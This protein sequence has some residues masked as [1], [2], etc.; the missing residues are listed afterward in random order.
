M[1]IE[2]C[3]DINTNV[4]EIHIPPWDKLRG[5]YTPNQKLACFVLI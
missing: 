1:Y 5:V 3:N 4:F 2:I